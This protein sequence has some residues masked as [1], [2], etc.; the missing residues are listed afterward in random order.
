MTN[1]SIPAEEQP[2]DPGREA[3]ELVLAPPQDRAFVA[4][5]VNPSVDSAAAA[6]FMASESRTDQSVRYFEQRY[7]AV[8]I[9]PIP[10]PKTLRELA[11]IYPDALRLIFEDFHAQSAHR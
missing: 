1:E 5:T 10:D 2:S 4:D 7:Q 8:H 11:K 6:R 3:A 9:G